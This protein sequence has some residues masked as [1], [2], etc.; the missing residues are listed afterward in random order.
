MRLIP[1]KTKVKIEFFKGISIWDILIGVVGAGLEIAILISSLPYRFYVMLGVGMIFAGLLVR[2]D[3]T[4]NYVYLLHILRHFCY[5]R[6]FERTLDDDALLLLNGQKDRNEAVEELFDKS[7]KAKGK[8]EDQEIDKKS[9]KE[10]KKAEAALFKEENRKLKDKKVSEEEKNEIWKARAQRSAEKKRVRSQQK[11]EYRDNHPM[12]EMI[13]YTDIKDGYISYGGKYYGVVLEIPPVEFRFFSQ[14]RRNTSIEA[15]VGKVLRNINASY[16]ANIVKIDRPINYD[17]YLDKEYEKLEEL[18]RSFESGLM[19]E[20]ELKP[21]VEVLYDRLNELNSLCYDD[22]VI[23]PYYYIVLYEGDKKQLDIQ[24][25]NAL[26]SL[27]YGEIDAHKLDDKEL[28][29]FLKYTNEIDFDERMIEKIRPEDYAT[30][31]MPQSVVINPRTVEVNHIMTYNFRMSAFPTLVDDAWLA[32]VMSM[33]A[34]KVVVKCKPMERDKAMRAIDR[35]LGELRGQLM[36]TGLDSK[37][38]ELQE[39]IDTLGNLLATLQ[40]ENENLLQVNVYVTAYDIAGTRANPKIKQPPISRRS[41]YG[42]MKKAV[43][44]LYQEHGF[45]LVNMEFDQ[46]QAFIGSQISGYDPLPKEARGIPS[47]SVAAAY[48]WV[49]ANVSDEGGMKLGSSEGVPVF[50]N[51]FRRDSERVNSNMVIVGK[52]GS[53]KS[54][55]TKDILTNL[56]AEDAKIFILDPEN[57]YSELAENLH[58]KFINVGN[59]QQG[60][61]NPFQ[62]ITALDDDESDGETVTGSYATHLQFLEEFFRQILPDCDKDALEYLSNLV[63]RMYTNFGITGETD[64]SKLTPEDYPIFDDLYDAVLAEFQQTDNEYIRTMLR[65]LMNYIAKFSTGGRNANIWNGPSTITTDENFTVFNFQSL[66]ANRNGTI[67]NAQ[68]LLVLKYVDNEIIKNRDYNTKYNLKRKV[69]VAIDEA[70]VFI[71]TKFPVALDFMFQLAKRIRKYNGMQIVITQ[72]IKDFVGS[73]EIARKSTAIINASQY[74]LIFALAPNDMEDLCTLYEKAGGINEMEQERITTA[75]RGQAFTV[76]GPTSRSTFRVEVPEPIVEMFQNRDYVCRYFTGEGGEENWEDFVGDSRQLWLEN[77]PK[78]LERAAKDDGAKKKHVIFTELSE[79]EAALEQLGN[80]VEEI[81]EKPKH[82][83]FEEIPEKPQ[84]P[85]TFEE[86][87]EE[88]QRHVTFEEIPEE[89]QGHVTFEEIPREAASAVAAAGQTVASGIRAAQE[90]AQTVA[91]VAAAAVPRAVAQMTVPYEEVAQASQTREET[92]QQA[93]SQPGLT[94][95]EKVLMQTLGQFSHAAMIEE[96]KKAVREEVMKE[97]AGV[98][99]E[100][101]AASV[102]QPEGTKQPEAAYKPEETFEQKNLE[103]PEENYEPEGTYEWENLEQPEENYEPEDLEQPETTYEP[104][105]TELSKELLQPE[106]TEAAEEDDGL[107]WLLEGIESE[108]DEAEDTEETGESE[109][110]GV[111]EENEVSEDTEEAEEAEESEVPEESEETETMEEDDLSWLLEED[112]ETA[113]GNK[114]EAIDLM[115][116]LMKQADEMEDIDPIDMMDIY[117]EKVADITLEELAAYIQKHR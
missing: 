107:S 12:E 32:T 1:G 16:S 8:R 112:D 61:I 54:Y 9:L 34:T 101:G 30:F 113:S 81:L 17:R 110:T 38:M 89:P 67:A 72:N 28:A 96:I 23:A 31:A 95:L 109:E 27:R 78:K 2:L 68:M 79:E 50:L 29:V 83:T 103:Q 80:E 62:I 39:H 108:S 14:H 37:A 105:E 97:L 84:G 73:E 26:D 100:T 18:K 94:E 69:V 102:F 47:N 60:R 10:K 44:R 104:E 13:P 65:S 58:G 53:G 56:A 111:T 35:S 70:H 49:F 116:I 99:P 66:L 98:R 43:R 114:A 19:S 42:G 88:S 7:K 85:V 115:D 20:E 36:T 45:R 86:I 11:E 51:F 25:N 106:E 52:S 24:V 3:A 21:R 41:S 59:G 92:T 74:S 48:P 82:V 5:K 64:L 6:H 15:G 71:D 4:P 75:P 117:D 46:T 76:L 40:Q 63:D 33:P 57:E 90:T 93:T 77:R 87:P 22:P 91:G 55:A